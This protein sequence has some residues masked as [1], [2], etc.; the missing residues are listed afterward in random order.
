MKTTLMVVMEDDVIDNDETDCE[1]DCDT[2]YECDGDNIL[3]MM[4]AT[5][6]VVMA[7]M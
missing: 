4:T 2:Y 3:M 6:L 7:V 5:A 1:G